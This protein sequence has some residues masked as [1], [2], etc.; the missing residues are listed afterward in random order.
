M[1]ISFFNKLIDFIFGQDEERYKVEMEKFKKELISACIN[2]KHHLFGNFSYEG[3]KTIF[4]LL[5]SFAKE[6]IIINC[7]S[8]DVL[9]ND[10]IFPL[11]NLTC[12]RFNKKNNEVLVITYD[13][14]KSEK[15]LE[16]EKKYKSFTYLPCK[17][18]NIEKYNN[19]I[20]VDYTK[21]WL[22]DIIFNRESLNDQIKACVNFNDPVKA[23]QLIMFANNLEIKLNVS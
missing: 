10:E 7:K 20:I 2:Q 8:Y 12:E 3:Y 11:F 22:E 9:F 23:A 16:L 18:D 14:N 19:F 21:Y 6:K 17:C 1:K 4:E 13:G 15:F 5:M